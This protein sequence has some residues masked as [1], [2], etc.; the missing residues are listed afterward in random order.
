VGAEFPAKKGESP[1]VDYSIFNSNL[2]KQHSGKFQM[3]IVV[4]SRRQTTSNSSFYLTNDGNIFLTTTVSVPEE[5][6]KELKKGEFSTYLSLSYVI[7]E[8]G[9]I[10]TSPVKFDGKNIFYTRFVF[11]KDKFKLVGFYSE[12]EGDP[13][14]E[15]VSG[16]FSASM[17][18]ANLSLSDVVFNKFS[19]EDILK[20]LSFDMTKKRQAKRADK[21]TDEN[22]SLSSNLRI[23]NFK[24]DD[25]GNS[26]LICSNMLNYSRRVCSGSGTSRSCSYQYYCDKDDTYLFKVD[27]KGKLE[28]SARSPRHFSYGGWNI[29]DQVVLKNVNNFFITYPTSI[30]DDSVALKDKKLKKISLS[31]RE[32]ME[33]LVFNSSNNSLSKKY[34]Y[35]N[36]PDVSRSKRLK[37]Y[38]ENCYT[39]SDGFYDLQ[40]DYYTPTGIAVMNTTLSIATAGI[41]YLLVRGSVKLSTLRSRSKIVKVFPN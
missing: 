1:Y 18:K 6:K 2:E 15:K 16:I 9:E 27:S 36:S 23:E 37:L 17:D 35:Y 3:P 21:I 14:G 10:K 39:L 11:E 12:L 22:A 41:Y 25:D 34:L 32:K 31:R 33:Y 19:K 5:E 28:F 40:N 13:T 4:T 24:T 26:Y 38:P 7:A 8:T 30:D 29:Y 20:L